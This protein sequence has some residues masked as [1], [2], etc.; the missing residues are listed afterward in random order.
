L[1][2]VSGANTSRATDATRRGLSGSP[3]SGRANVRPFPGA[4]F[5]TNAARRGARPA[6]PGRATR[7]G[8][9]ARIRKT[10]AVAAGKRPATAVQKRYTA[11]AVPATVVCITAKPGTTPAKGA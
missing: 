5:V 11:A 1:P 6:F 3:S 10:V 9:L 4:G 8:V 2:P 7:G